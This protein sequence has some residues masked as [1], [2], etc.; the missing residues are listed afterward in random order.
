MFVLGT[1]V[2]ALSAIRL[3]GLKCC[4]TDFTALRQDCLPE[5]NPGTYAGPWDQA[6][7]TL[8]AGRKNGIGSVRRS[9]SSSHEACREGPSGRLPRAARILQAVAEL[10]S[11]HR[12]SRE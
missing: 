1:G 10:S 8:H 7:D 4:R 12:L 11:R 3:L 6:R 2:V 5:P 9:C